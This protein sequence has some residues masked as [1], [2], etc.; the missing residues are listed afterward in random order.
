MS[1]A[2]K[3]TVLADWLTENEVTYAELAE[4]L[5]VTEPAI[6]HY[7]AGRNRPSAE[8]LVKLSEITGISGRALL[9][10]FEAA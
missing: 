3:M 4:K 10:S 2:T 6:H 8:T 1:K 5:G 7:I 9:S